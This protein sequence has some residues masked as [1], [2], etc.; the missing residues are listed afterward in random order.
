MAPK[1]PQ[2]ELKIICV[3]RCIPEFLARKLL[4]LQKNITFV[5]DPVSD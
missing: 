4:Y 1:S 2:R 3:V 5:A